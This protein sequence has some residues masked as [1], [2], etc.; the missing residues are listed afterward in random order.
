MNVIE[1]DQSVWASAI[2]TARR[3]DGSLRFSVINRNMNAI[4]VKDA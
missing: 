2:I 3:K 4:T 1:P